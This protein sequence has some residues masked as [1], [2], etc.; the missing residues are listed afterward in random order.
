M[1]YKLLK[2]ISSFSAGTILLSDNDSRIPFDSHPGSD[3]VNHLFRNHK[4]EYFEE[5]KETSEP[6]WKVGDKAVYTYTS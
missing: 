2:D 1:K 4:E 5:V 3:L 6:R